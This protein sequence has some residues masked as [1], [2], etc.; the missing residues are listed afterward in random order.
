MTLDDSFA[1]SAHGSAPIGSSPGL[2]FLH[3]GTVH[4]FHLV[5]L[6]VYPFLC[7]LINLASYPSLASRAS[8]IIAVVVSVDSSAQRQVLPRR[9][10]TSQIIRFPSLL[11][12]GFFCADRFLVLGGPSGG[13]FL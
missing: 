9:Y 8:Q 10:P 12:T 5:F 3:G 11:S 6:S 2:D 4:F 7:G 1:D 13:K